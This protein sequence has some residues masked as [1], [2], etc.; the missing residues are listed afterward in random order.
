MG[1]WLVNLL[2]SW[3][4]GKLRLLRKK[5][6][7]LAFGPSIVSAAGAVYQER[8][9]AGTLYSIFTGAEFCLR[10]PAPFPHPFSNFLEMI[11]IICAENCTTRHGHRYRCK[12]RKPCREFRH[13]RPHLF[14]QPQ[15]HKFLRKSTLDPDQELRMNL[16]LIANICV[17]GE[18]AGKA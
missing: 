11:S 7:K 16:S 14:S 13:N 9:D 8:R 5:Y 2:L 15:H 10:N 1:V 4:L 17:A 3:S 18:P 6:F 12:T